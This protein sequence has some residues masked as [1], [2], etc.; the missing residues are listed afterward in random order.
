MKTVFYAGL[1]ALALFE[2]AKVYLIMPLPG[3]Q[4]MDSLEVAFFLHAHRWFF[5]IPLLLMIALGSGAAFQTPRKRLPVAVSLATL[6]VFWVFN[7]A[8]SAESMFQPPGPLTF[9]PKSESQ[10]DEESVVIGVEWGG[11]FKAYPIRFLVFHHQVQDTIAGKPILVTYCSVCRTGRVFEPR[12]RGQPEKFRLV[13]MDHFNA[14]FEDATTGSWWRQSTGEAVAG[15]LQGESLPEMECRQLAL[16]KCFAL[17]PGA[18]VMQPEEASKE[19][20]DKE[21]KFERGESKGKL[22]RTDRASWGEK[23]WIVGIQMNGVSKAYDWNRLS[24]RRVINDRLGE[25]PIVLALAGDQRS[26][27]VFERPPDSGD[28][29]IREDILLANEKSYDLSGRPVGNPSQP[30]KRVT[31]HQEFWHSWRTFHPATL[32]D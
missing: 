13:G 25:T 8:M 2:I 19:D 23:S 20:Y 11:E 7:F 5:R 3:S 4:R 26:F 32:R 15:P 17:H 14:M 28:F 10:V 1:A 16:R 12:V 18:L 31:A 30:L 6:A 24:E 29:S 21:G 9:L 27:A 22:T